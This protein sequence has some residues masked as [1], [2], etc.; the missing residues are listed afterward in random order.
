M[1]DVT[2]LEKL[3]YSKLC[4]SDRTLCE[5]IFYLSYYTCKESL[6]PLL[7]CKVLSALML[8]KLVVNGLS[9]SHLRQIHTRDPENGIRNVFTEPLTENPKAARIT[10]S[11]KVIQKVVEYFSL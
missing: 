6:E 9:L 4:L 1:A 11:A 5:D 3:Y 7:R 8:R 2:S 10:K